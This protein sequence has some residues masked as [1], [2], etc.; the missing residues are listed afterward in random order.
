[1]LFIYEENHVL[2][3]KKSSVKESNLQGFSTNL[4]IQASNTMFAVSQ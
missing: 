2:Q 4:R 3:T 1:M